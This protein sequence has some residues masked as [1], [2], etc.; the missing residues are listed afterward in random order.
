MAIFSSTNSTTNAG[1]A[2]V[3]LE[4]DFMEAIEAHM[5]WKM[6]LSAYIDGKSEEALD[7]Q[8]VGSDEKC[9][10]GRWIYGPG[11][12]AYGNNPLFQQLVEQHALFHQCASAVIDQVDAGDSGKARYVLEEGD[13]S[14]ISQHVKTTLARL[15][16]DAAFTGK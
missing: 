7:A 9:A 2:N 1:G 13:Y 8:V 3:A 14:K 15:S 10:L 12:E 16:R 11:K 4:M 6:R 5:A